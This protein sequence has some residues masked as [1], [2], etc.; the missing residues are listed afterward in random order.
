MTDSK[1]SCT[2]IKNTNK[3]NLDR[4]YEQKIIQL[5]NNNPNTK[6]NIQWIPSHVGISGNETADRLANVSSNNTSRIHLT[7]KIPLTDAKRI[8][9][10]KIHELWQQHYDDCPVNIGARHRSIIQSTIPKNPWFKEINL[11]SSDTRRIARIRTG[12]TFDK[13]FLKTIN[14]SENQI[15]DTCNVIEDSF[16]I[17]INCS[18]YN[19]IRSKYDSINNGFNQHTG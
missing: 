14:K 17:I 15:C 7:L 18:K 5:A 12:H 8:A 9:K 1:S 2:S 11:N 6:F 16:H 10:L 4:Y 19:L 13:R 3:N